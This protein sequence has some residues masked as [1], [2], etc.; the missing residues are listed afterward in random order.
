LIDSIPLVSLQNQQ[1]VCDRLQQQ[2]ANDPPHTPH[3]RYTVRLA[4][5]IMVIPP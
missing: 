2:P 4:T 1:D 3:Q 5:N